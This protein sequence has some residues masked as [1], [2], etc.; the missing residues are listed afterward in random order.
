MKQKKYTS[1]ILIAIM[2]F[3]AVVT[4]QLAHAVTQ[5]ETE[6]ILLTDQVDLSELEGNSIIES[7]DVLEADKGEVE[8]THSSNEEESVENEKTVAED[9]AVNN[10][11]L[12]TIANNGPPMQE[13]NMK[14]SE[15]LSEADNV[16]A[17]SVVQEQNLITSFNF[18]LYSSDGEKS[19]VVSGSDQELD[20]NA[21]NSIQ[22]SYGIT[23]PNDL[24]IIA[25]DTYQI[26]LPE[27]LQSQA[28]EGKEI[29]VEGV[30][31]AT[32]TIAEGQLTI[33]FKEE[34]NEFDDVELFAQ[35]SGTLNKELFE[36][37]H[38]V[39]IEVPYREGTSYTANLKAKQQLYEGKDQ[40]VAGKPYVLDGKEKIQTNHNPEYVDWTVRVNDSMD[41]YEKAGVIDS[42]DENLEIVEGSFV[43]EKINRNYK[44]EE[45][46][47]EIID[48]ISPTI[49]KSGFELNLGSIKDAY[50]ITYTTKLIRPDGGGNLSINNHARIILDNDE[51]TVNDAVNVS[52]SGDIPTIEKTGNISK[53]NA[54]IIEWQVEYNY[55]QEEL[56][57][58]VLLT[59][60]LS[61]GEVKLESVRIME[62][63]TDIDG[64][65]TEI[66]LVDVTPIL[67]DGN[68]IIPG[69]DASGKSYYITFQSTI[70]VGLNNKTIVNTIT[71]NYSNSDDASVTANTIPKGDKIGE[72]LVDEQGNPYIK[73]TI[74][75]NTQKVNVSSIDITDVFDK[76]FLIFDTADTKLFED[77][78]E[79][80]SENYSVVPYTH[81]DGRIGFKLNIPKSGPHEFTFEYLTYY[82]AEGMQQPELANNAE[83][84]FDKG[85]GEGIAVDIGANQ[86]GPKAGIKKYGQY[87]ANTG[88]TEQQ[89]EWTID[90]NESNIL[91]NSGSEIVDEFTSNNYTMINNTLTVMN[92]SNQSMLVEGTDYTV[93]TNANGFVLT[94]SKS[95]NA[96][97]QI[98]YKTTADET[99]N[100]DRTNKATLKW[101]G[102]S[103]EAV[104]TVKKRDP[105]INKTGEVVTNENGSKSIRW[106]VS[107]NTNNNV[108]HDFKLTDTYTPSSVEV[109][110]IKV[111]SQGIDVTDQF[112]ISPERTGG[113]FTLSKVKLDAKTYQLTYT[114][115]LSPAEE[116]QEIKNSA[117]ITY[118]GGQ[119][120]AEAALPKPTLGVQKDAINIDKTVSPNLINWK[121][122]A[123]TDPK[124]AKHFVNLVNAVLTDTI[125]ADQRLVAS[126]IKVVRADNKLDVTDSVNIDSTDNTFSVHLPDGPY[127]YVVTFQTEI[128]EY[129]SVNIKLDRYT[130]TTQLANS[131]YEPVKDDAYIDYYGGKTGN[132][133]QKS[134]IQNTD[135]ENIDWKLT[136]NP[137]GL[138]IKNSKITDT[139]SNNH[140]YIADSVVVMDKDGKA[141]DGYKVVFE[142]D[143]RSFTIELGDIQEPYQVS[144]STRLNEDLVGK[145]A[146]KNTIELF[147]G[148]EQKSIDKQVTETSSQQW[149]YGGG[150]S[151]RTV[152]FELTKFNSDGISLQGA[153]FE[154]S[155]VNFDNSTTPT[156]AEIVTNE[157]G[158]YL[159]GDIRAGRYMLTE[160]K[161]PEGFE[162]LEKPIYFTIGYSETGEGYT[163]TITNPQWLPANNTATSASGNVLTIIN[164]YTAITVS[165]EAIK[166]LEGNKALEENQFMFELVAD[167][168]VIDTKSNDSKGKITFKEL[169]F[170]E[171]GTYHYQMREVKGGLAGVAYDT[172]VHNVTVSVV[173]DQYG[174]LVANVSYGS[175]TP[176]FTNTYKANSVTIGFKAEKILEGQAL[177]DEQ[178]KFELLDTEGRIIQTVKNKTNGK[179]EFDAITYNEVGE[180]AYTIRE[181]KGELGGITYDSSEFPVNVKVTD[182]GEGQLRAAET[183]LNGPATFTNTYTAQSG[184]VILKADKILVGQGLSDK[185][186]E[187]ELVDSTG[188]V[189]QTVQNR[190][191]GQILFA[192]MSY[193]KVGENTYTIREVQ[194]KLGGVT[195][196][197]TQFT[198][199]VSVEDNGIGN[200]VVTEN[201]INGPATFTNRY[202]PT[203]HSI[204]LKASKKLT[205]LDLAEG[206]FE[207][208]LLD[209][210]GEVLQ[211]K[212]NSADGK[213]DFNQ[214]EYD[215]AGTY[216]YTIREV[217]GSQKGMTYD[218]TEYPVVVEVVDNGKGNLEATAHYTE[219][220]AQFINEYVPAPDNIVIE[221][222]KVLKGQGL[223]A[224]QFTF[225][226]VSEQGKVIQNTTNNAEGKILFD[227]IIYDEVGEYKYT[228]REAEG[229]QGGVTYDSTEYEV[230]VTVT[231]DKEGNLHAKA[232]YSAEKV[233]FTN[234]YSA[235]EGSATIKASK[236]LEGQ[237]IREEQFAFNLLNEKEEV[238]QTVTNT[239]EGQIIFD[240]LLFEEP[241]EYVYF[242]EE[243]NNELGG[244]TYDEN[245]Y[246]AIVTVMDNGNG[247]LETTVE[248]S[249]EPE[250]INHY[251]AAPDSVHFY[252][253]KILEGQVLT[254]NQF[255]FELLDS[256]GKVLQT[257]KNDAE[258]QVEFDYIS[259]NS[260]GEHTYIIREVKGGLGGVTYDENEFH[261]DVVVTDNGN[262][263]LIAVETY[264]DGPAVF[265]NQYIP[266]PDSVVFEADKVLEGQKLTADQFTFELLDA[267]G[268]VLQTAKNNA[269][270]QIIFDQIT[271]G[272]VGEHTYTIREVKG[273]LSGMTYDTKEF[274]V[275]VKVEDNGQGNLVATEHYLDGPAVFTNQYV[276]AADSVVLE[277]SKLLNGL[278][279]VA[280]QF[281][282]ELVDEAG[283]IIQTSTNNATGQVM[284]DAITYDEVG[285][286]SYIIREVAGSQSGITYDSNEF[287]VDV[288]VEDNGKG[289]LVAAANYTDG[290]AVFI[291]QYTPE[292]D[293]LVFEANKVLNGKEL[294]ADQFV[295]E[296]VDAEGQ[297]L[298]TAKNNA[299]G[300]II[301]D[302]IS[303]DRAGTYTYTIREVKGNQIGILYDDSEYAI[304]VEVEDNEKG[305]LVAVKTYIDGPASFINEYIPMESIGSGTSNT[306][307]NPSESTNSKDS[308]KPTEQ[309]KAKP[310][311][312]AKA[313]HSEKGT[314]G[315]MRLPKTGEAASYT[316]LAFLILITGLSL[317]YYER[318]KGKQK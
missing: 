70:P 134:G 9:E 69:L 235:K 12:D 1:I 48:N 308:S 141:L 30:V 161:A 129:P 79:V 140:V 88:K 34:V 168:S 144:Y 203:P 82:T 35:V 305:Q 239:A 184:K 43:I 117:A 76:K 236:H 271:Y 135:T 85:N 288:T 216:L 31:V 212:K 2:L 272:E 219:G 294:A 303:Y 311:L 250:F 26:K 133:S 148:Q 132:H 36:T 167:G 181:V 23:K 120:K 6:G 177:K 200:L 273:E 138:A 5:E 192:E 86:T 38:E 218:K 73:W 157:Q 151:G 205:G 125:P 42:L 225:E 171:I 28:V 298:Q 13:K 20:L 213:I 207:F 89:V 107:F 162:K 290:A 286:Y 80:G 83:L 96:K 113:S 32:Y 51:N 169:T 94:L 259:Y 17:T 296:L 170:D 204:E 255:A 150:G 247:Q 316:G 260:V 263:Q 75:M 131:G 275:S 136:V 92:R 155:R 232:A 256:E 309:A 224:G 254:A 16:R 66:G 164:N 217:L 258:G 233:V 41:S 67:K 115:T 47:R 302:E 87:V 45:I 234:H 59:D 299:A 142:P 187:F 126:T 179:I 189:L 15:E 10:K 220:S 267:G 3:N 284:F 106:T 198:V 112:T 90:F 293:S 279:L 145:F 228:I 44:N 287:T 292:S 4:P 183:Y 152:Q 104:A 175:E 40:K 57:L 99:N 244:V 37:E 261:F 269:D 108:I 128:L 19:E 227:E 310:A 301:F 8:L 72:Q 238:I 307:K 61:H 143:N 253:K 105:G 281:S 237:Q 174:K 55:G 91:L 243:V 114:T 95:T 156:K 158:I 93:T 276:P 78:V 312:P 109:S 178:F 97:L 100:V 176:T 147:G 278:E 163:A 222:E 268:I 118:T 196:D 21:V 49:T 127:Q 130:N 315:E 58:N 53:T 159:S 52:W 185:Q 274:M 103:Q 317:V 64:N 264:V 230:V 84:I 119:D 249:E 62:V 180:Y 295:F 202:V 221:A 71:D 313:A 101:Q 291:N 116:K 186:F 246:T 81:A 54:D 122:T 24:Q 98:K 74:T 242:I 121:I 300:Q 166:S 63:A 240:D 262:G 214:I 197:P 25:G 241:G 304:M 297:V 139:L 190:A 314:S 22:L 195:Y 7:V 215:T 165:L 14:S 102:G 229:V 153:E 11:E 318:K 193:D 18:L 173:N 188:K 277:A 191:D 211:T 124:K 285:Q 251:T 280:G 210:A 282:F 199:K 270:G 283:K 257:A 123:N 209:E 172:S 154:L 39:V 208:E 68:M 160:T 110:Q 149:F 289:N 29:I 77:G 252:A 182:N 223:A 245:R 46:D 248:Y 146:V 111:T 50:E 137:D 201:Y 27:V 226:L 306:P 266:S 65:A 60:T 231:D 194:S 56:G 265:K 206:Q 33:T